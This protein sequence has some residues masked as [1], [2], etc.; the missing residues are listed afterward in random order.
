MTPFVLDA[1]T[2]GVSRSGVTSPPSSLCRL[3]QLEQV[4]IFRLSGRGLL[5]GAGE[6]GTFLPLELTQ[7]VLRLPEQGGLGHGP[8]LL[9]RR[10]QPTEEAVRPE[11]LVAQRDRLR[12]CRQDFV[13]LLLDLLAL[14]HG[15]IP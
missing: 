7:P 3:L 12:L 11:Q 14:G 13:D 6:G 9:F 10:S 4:A 1:D 5:H 8:P 15:R 2:L